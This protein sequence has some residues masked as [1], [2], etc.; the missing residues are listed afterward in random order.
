MPSMDDGLPLPVL[1]WLYA[2]YTLETHG[3]TILFALVLLY[4]ARAQYSAFAERRHR[5]RVL[6]AA[7]DPTRVAVLRKETAR[8]RQQQQ[9]A[10]QAKRSGGAQAKPHKLA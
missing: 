9:Q 10:L 1:I 2:Q 8:V 4:V 7:N 3:W 5:Q 6:S